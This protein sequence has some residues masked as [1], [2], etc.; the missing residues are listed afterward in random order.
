MLVFLIPS[1]FAQNSLENERLF[2]ESTNIALDVK[3]GEDIIKY[4][5]TT[6]KTTS[7]INSASI[8]FY[9]DEIN[10]SDSRAKVY[11]NGNAF[12]IAN[13]DK[14]IIIY[15]HYNKLLENYKVNVHFAGQ[16][17]LVNY[18][19]AASIQQPETI[20]PTNT[21]I[22]KTNIDLHILTDQ[23]ERVYNK[24]EY[25]FF[26]KTFDDSIYSGS[27]FEVFQG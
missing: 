14:G 17:G 13:I 4:G 10:M 7:T 20:E 18:P 16:N 19:M 5:S 27:D 15:G 3:F 21:V 9:G 6:I 25:K 22:S 24:T 8:T 1:A 26:V 11:A 23:H 2:A 12:S